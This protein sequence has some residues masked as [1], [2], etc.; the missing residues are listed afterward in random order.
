MVKVWWDVSP[1]LTQQFTRLLDDA[2]KGDA[3]AATR[4]LPLVY[5]QLRSLA[6]QHMASERAGH[7]LQAT[8][9]VHEAYLKLV[10]NQ[11]IR[12]SGRSHF[13]LAAAEAMRR[14]LI[15]HARARGGP[16]RGGARKRVA[17]NN[18]LDLAA[19]ERFP[20]FLAVDDAISRLEKESPDLARIVRLRFYGGL[21]VDETAHVQGVSASTVRRDW[22]Y[23]RAWLMRQLTDE[24]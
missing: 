3:S 9:L 23:A 13:F 6:R 12:W 7:T 15:D 14:I 19:E 4:L 2:Q 16:K 5:E 18:V 11:D 8:A 1:E 22:T 24:A 10:G 21:S 17:M 20:E